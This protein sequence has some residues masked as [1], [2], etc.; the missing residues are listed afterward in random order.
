[1]F[2]EFYHNSIRKTVTGFGTLFN[3]IFITRSNG[4]GNTQRIKVPL[5]YSNKEKFIHRLSVSLA[6]LENQQTQITLPRLSFSLTN[7]AYDPERKK[8]SIVRR[9]RTEVDTNNNDINKYHFSNIPYNLEFTLSIYT[10]NTDDG[11]QIVEQILP[12]FTPEFTITIKPDILGDT[13]EKLD[14]PIVLTQVTPTEISEGM[15]STEATR[16]I[17]WDLTFT[18][19]TMVYG[20]VKDVGLIKHIEANFFH[21]ED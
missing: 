3:N 21:L 13:D 12:F 11:I 19:K 7:V 5:T 4:M 1:M 15:L 9:F 6:D 20:P 14:I 17:T 10:R 2:A 16:L 18:A 8:N